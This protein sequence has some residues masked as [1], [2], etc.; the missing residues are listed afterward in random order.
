MC[1]PETS[2]Y[3]LH[4]KRELRSKHLIRLGL[5]FHRLSEPHNEPHITSMC[6]GGTR[7]GTAHSEFTGLVG[8]GQPKTHEAH[9]VLPTNQ[10]VVGSIPASRTN[11]INGLALNGASPLC[12]SQSQGSTQGSTDDG[13]FWNCFVSHEQ[14]RF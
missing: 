2:L 9:S 12:F 3:V 6:G 10:G 11:K 8:V 13:L 4:L 1:R 5:V 14:S 7:T